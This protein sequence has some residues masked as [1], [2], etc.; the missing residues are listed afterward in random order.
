MTKNKK[1]DNNLIP[2]E[3]KQQKNQ[4]G[5]ELVTQEQE[6][7]LSKHKLS[8]LVKPSNSLTF[9]D[10]MLKEAEYLIK[11]NLMPDSINT[12][13]KVLLIRQMATELGIAPGMMYSHAFVLNGKACI[14]GVIAGAVLRKGGIKWKTIEDAAPVYK[15]DIEGKIIKHKKVL[16]PK[17]KQYELKPDKEGD[18]GLIR[19]KRTT[20]R[21]YRDE[22]QEDVSWTMTEAKEAG[23]LDKKVWRQYFR[24]MMWWRTFAIGSRRVG[25]DLIMGYHT[26]E[27]YD[28]TG[29]I[30]LDEIG[31][32]KQL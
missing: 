29:T 28:E 21:F 9:T 26:I 19:D 5:E 14:D 22:I 6:K 31:E 13:E 18:R 4:K 3:E 11:T 16:N 20:I 23:L 32:A 12:P 15:T 17:T 1:E 2:E 24:V 7:E 27:E 8:K 30:F 25:P 10:K